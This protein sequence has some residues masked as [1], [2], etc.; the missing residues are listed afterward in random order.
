MHPLRQSRD[1]TISRYFA[2]FHNWIIKTGSRQER[3]M[4]RIYRNVWNATT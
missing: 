2:G 1:R 4:N 3:T